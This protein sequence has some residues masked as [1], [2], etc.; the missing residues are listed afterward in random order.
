M[1][2]TDELEWQFYD[3]DDFC[4]RCG[5]SGEIVRGWEYPEYFDCPDCKGF[6]KAIDWLDEWDEA[7]ERKRDDGY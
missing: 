3:C 1:S 4:E 7:Y 6:G 5:G 2:D